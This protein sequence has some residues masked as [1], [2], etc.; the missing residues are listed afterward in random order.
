MGR[1]LGTAAFR[2]DLARVSGAVAGEA[3]AT[4]VVAG[5]LIVQ[6]AAKRNLRTNA[7]ADNAAARRDG[8]RGTW[9]TGN[10]ARS[11]HVG[12][13]AAMSELGASSGGDIGEAETSETRASV[14][15]GTDVQYAARIEFGFAGRDRLGRT[16]S[17]SPQPFL[18]PA[19]DE[20]EDAVM[21]EIRDVLADQ[22]E[23]AIKGGGG[24]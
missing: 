11:I 4:A 2:R 12:G 7:S 5:A 18:R 20:N 19:V 6:G 14:A 21:T 8:R 13:H 24:R 10:L 1:D 15:V 23:R 17:Q 16:Y 9:R 3:L 22:I